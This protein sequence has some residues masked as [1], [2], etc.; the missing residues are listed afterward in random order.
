MISM[1]VSLGH[2]THVYGTAIIPGLQVSSLQWSERQV[3]DKRGKCVWYFCANVQQ[4]FVF[5]MIAHSLQGSLCKDVSQMFT[6][7]NVSFLVF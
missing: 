4:K 1:P 5:L 3:F 6:R 2:G 7:P